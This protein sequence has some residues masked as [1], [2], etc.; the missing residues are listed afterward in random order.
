MN[1]QDCIKSLKVIKVIT[2][3]GDEATIEKFDMSINLY[4]EPVGQ[5]M[6]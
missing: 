6:K 1:W 5:A 2:H 4:G 3:K